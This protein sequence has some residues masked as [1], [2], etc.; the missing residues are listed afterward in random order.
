[1]YGIDFDLMERLRF[2]SLSEEDLHKHKHKQ[3]PSHTDNSKATKTTYRCQIKIKGHIRASTSV[4]F[5]V[6]S[7][8]Q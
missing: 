4:P 5:V 1:M 8:A 6:M 7:Y 2:V 3:N